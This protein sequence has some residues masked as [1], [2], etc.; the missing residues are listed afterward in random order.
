MVAVALLHPAAF[1]RFEPKGHKL[2]VAALGARADQPVRPG[3]LSC[4]WPTA[5][6]PYVLLTPSPAKQLRFDQGP[7]NTKL[8]RDAQKPPHTHTHTPLRTLDK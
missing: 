3:R 1:S 8:A 6:L 5:A 2:Q 4:G 7:R